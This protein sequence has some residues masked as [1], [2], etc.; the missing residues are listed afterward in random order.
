MTHRARYDAKARTLRLVGNEQ[1]DLDDGEAVLLEWQRARSPQTHRH[2]FAWLREAWLTLPDHLHDM[3]WAGSPETM[4]KHAL[5][6]TG[7]HSATVLDMADRKAAIAAK[8]ALLRAHQA[9]HG[10]AIASVRDSVLTIWTPESQSMKAMGRERFQASKE[11]V[12]TWVAAQLEVTPDDLR[13]T[14]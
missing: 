14:A 3:P 6:A 7:Y 2:Q 1:V 10:Y 5:I 12:L 11:A 4:R 9:A 13:R 8:V